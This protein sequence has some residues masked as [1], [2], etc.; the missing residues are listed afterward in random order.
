M[1]VPLPTALATALA[2]AKAQ[3]AAGVAPTIPFIPETRADTRQVEAFGAPDALLLDWKSWETQLLGHAGA[4]RPY[5]NFSHG[6]LA[7]E[8]ERIP[9]MLNERSQSEPFPGHAARMAA[10]AERWFG[11]PIPGQSLDAQLARV[12]DPKYWRRF[13]NVRVRQAREHL[14]LK[15]GLIG[16]G[17][18]AYCSADAQ[19]TRTTQLKKQA[20]WL[21][22]TV[23]RAVINGKVVEIPLE[24]VAKSERQKLAR[25]YA[26]IKAMDTLATESDLTGTM[27]TT[28]L[29]GEWHANPK[30]ANADHRWNGCTP[31]EANKELGERFQNIR[32]DLGKQ[33][34]CLS[35][36]W[37]GEPHQDGC[38]HRHHWLLYA[39][40]HERA[41]FAAFLKYFPGKIKLRRDDNGKN[42]E[43]IDNREDALRGLRR[44]KTHATE[45]AQIDVAVIDRAKGS[46]AA[47]VLKYV[48][49]AV[50]SETT[51][52]DLMQSLPGIEPE[53]THQAKEASQAQ[54]TLQSVDAH[55]SVWRMRSFQFFGIKN[56][57]SL[58]DE[59]RRVKQRPQE[60]HLLALWRLARGGDI[61]GTL[62]Q[63]TQRGD[64]YGFL[65][66]MGGLAAAPPPA[67]L[68]LGADAPQ[69]ARIYT[70]PT[71]TRYG[72]TGKRIEGVELVQPA[73]N[74][75]EEA[76]SLERIETR[77]V[78][79]EMVPKVPQVAKTEEKA[80]AGGGVGDAQVA[81]IVGIK[82]A[83]L[84]TK[85]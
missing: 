51:Y 57:L 52:E 2:R 61:E 66:A 32:R 46:G 29:E 43:I 37:A 12:E 58:W 77:A 25:L 80:K 9:K 69:R 68:E 82:S 33:G 18:R 50:L 45:G 11:V 26:F 76:V 19:Y 6:E 73:T 4:L 20:Q 55:R 17:A 40:E 63:G 21:K 42:D 67:Q 44:P 16:A 13:L 30:Y 39:P 60:A 34:V 28:T 81:K 74:K 53:P 59:L 75:D 56:C 65:K 27:L 72:E 47:Y 24:Q 83:A 41:V 78:R 1:L 38:P 70:S 84:Q 85:G 36:L 62:V 23:L 64:A 49:K 15:F 54:R 8:A 14:Y 22:D 48:M 5:L 7:D 35:G 31:M 10:A 3:H 71:T 79:W